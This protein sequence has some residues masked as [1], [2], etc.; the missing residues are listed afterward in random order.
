MR[1]AIL[2]QSL[3]LGGAQSVAI[4]L[5]NGFAAGNV[6]E[7][8]IVA[9]DGPSRAKLHSS[10]R[11]LLIPRLTKTS[12]VKTGAALIK[13]LVKIKPDVI[14]AHEAGIA[15]LA[16][17]CRIILFRRTP[18]ILTH[19]LYSFFRI[20]STVGYYAINRLLNGVIAISRSKE[21][22]LIK[23]GANPRKVHFVPNPIDLNT[24]DSRKSTLARTVERL[25]LGLPENAF[26]IMGAG[27]LIPKKRFDQFINIVAAHAAEFP[28][29][30]TIGLVLGDGPEA[31]KLAL[32]AKSVSNENIEIRLEGFQPDVLKYMVASDA[33]LFPTEFEEVQPMIIL[34]S[35]AA[36]VPLVCSTV[37][38]NTDIV[39]N[40][41]H[42]ITVSF[43]PHDYVTA[44][45]RIRTDSNLKK[46]LVSNGRKLIEA[47]YD[48]PA[49][50]AR[51]RSIYERLTT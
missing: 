15:L 34:E 28:S 19:H 51:T 26:L 25:A 44:L 5:A 38:G 16:S 20:P 14:H 37:A 4:A 11:L 42:A 2:C 3:E 1:I 30:K 41:V 24:L 40:E 18:I 21:K 35:L 23:G 9:A 39:T 32:I 27:R 13:A 43:K 33:V 29:Q 8:F 50:L 22:H 6:D 7:V 47:E 48:L 46:T 49:V 12:A 10:I 45:G 17:I 36:G 31:K